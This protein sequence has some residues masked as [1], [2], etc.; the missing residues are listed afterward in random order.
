[1]FSESPKQFFML[2][3]LK[4]SGCWGR[5]VN[6]CSVLPSSELLGIP[7]YCINNQKIVEFIGFVIVVCG[8]GFFLN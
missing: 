2:I 8:F 1:M 4:M 5:P 7:F 3:L 6:S